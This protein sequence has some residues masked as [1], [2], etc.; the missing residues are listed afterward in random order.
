MQDGRR[1]TLTTPR[2]G[3]LFLG[4]AGFVLIADQL[5]KHWIRLTRVPGESSELIPGI[6]DLTHVRN[7]GAA[8]GL[9]P[10]RQPIFIATSLVVLIVIAA[11]WRRASP[12]EWPVVAAMAS[13]TGGAVG[14]LID[15]VFQG[16]VTDFLSF[17]FIDFPVFNIADMGILAGVAVLVVWLLFAPEP[18]GGVPH[19]GEQAESSSVEESAPL[20]ADE[21]GAI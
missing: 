4:A 15:R 16:L 2:P 11:Y 13:I 19:A 12:R 17:A 20:P 6:I 5:T 9:F 7:A 14:N 1:I 10:G 21:T 8:F 18:S 3:W